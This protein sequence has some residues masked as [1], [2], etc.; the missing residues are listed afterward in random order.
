MVDRIEETLRTLSRDVE[1]VP[2]APS[3]AVRRRGERR[4]RNQLL[5]VTAVV[6]A[7][8]AGVAGVAGGVPG[9]TTS[10]PP[11]TDAPTVSTTQE[12]VLS[13]AADPLLRDGDLRDV[14]PF[15]AF[16]NSRTEPTD[17]LLRCIDVEG[18]AAAVSA[19]RVSTVLVEPDIGEPTVH[20]HALR[21]PSAVTARIFVDQLSAAF[22]SCDTGDPAEARV[23]DRGPYDVEGGFTASRL[24]IP[25][26]DAGIGYYE[27][28]VSRRGNVVVVLEWMSLGNPHGDT[29]ADWVWTTE[30]LRTALDRA[31]A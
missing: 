17:R 19:Q 28:G 6:V 12:P 27:L 31:V 30:R 10:A 7:L 3:G 14:G 1:V 16:L 23:I 9:R 15:A 22:A 8:V 25:T 26:A 13:L 24:T 5:A 4:T 18:G 21:F 2:L 29:A 11:A 20:E